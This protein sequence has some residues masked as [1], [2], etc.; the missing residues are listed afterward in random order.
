[1]QRP[2]LSGSLGRALGGPG[3]RIKNPTHDS[4][5]VLLGNG[6][7]GFSPYSVLAR[8]SNPSEE[9]IGDF[10]RAQLPDLAF[11][12]YGRNTYSVVLQ[13]C[14]SAEAWRRR[15][16][17][18][19]VKKKICAVPSHTPTPA[20]LKSAAYPVAEVRPRALAWAMQEL[21]SLGGCLC[22]RQDRA[23]RCGQLCYRLRF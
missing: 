9:T 19:L 21:C 5:S 11:G 22:I 13:R 12:S 6:Q 17:A 7:G 15:C 3:S 16:V 8:G 14:Q 1:V 4:V 23:P 10:K 18:F 20:A 2:P